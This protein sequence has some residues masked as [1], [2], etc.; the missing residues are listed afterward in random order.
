MRPAR[1]RRRRDGDRRRATACRPHLWRARRAVDVHLPNLAEHQ[2]KGVRRE[3][4]AAA[5]EHRDVA[6]AAV[7]RRRVRRRVHLL[8]RAHVLRAH[9]HRFFP[10]RPRHRRRGRAHGPRA[11]ARAWHVLP[12][13][14]G[15]LLL[16][17]PHR[18][19]RP[20]HFPGGRPLQDVLGARRRLHLLSGGRQRAAN[21]QQHCR[22]VRRD[23]RGGDLRARP[24]HEQKQR[25]RLL[26]LRLP[27][28]RALLHRAQLRQGQPFRDGEL[29]GAQRTGADP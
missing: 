18:P 23:G 15:Q 19:D 25:G 28:R 4:D 2:A 8:V 13:P 27:G 11:E 7:V 29:E 22:R 5:V 9:R 14:R 1:G 6:V 12:R 16:V 3:C 17:W 20:D 21:V 26:R 24:A 10:E